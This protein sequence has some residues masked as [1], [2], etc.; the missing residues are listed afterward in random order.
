[1][2]TTT[3]VDVTEDGVSMAV[4][5]FTSAPARKLLPLIVKVTA[6]AAVV[7]GGASD[8]NTGVVPV[9]GEITVNESVCDTPPPGSV[10]LEET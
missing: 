3:A 4:P 9:G 8:D 1:M 10:W 5:K 2:F 7:E 6:A